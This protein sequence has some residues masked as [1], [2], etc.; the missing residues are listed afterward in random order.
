[1]TAL[2]IISQNLV[3]KLVKKSKV[4]IQRGSSAWKQQIIDAFHIEKG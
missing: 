2:I 1:M 4:S 3:D